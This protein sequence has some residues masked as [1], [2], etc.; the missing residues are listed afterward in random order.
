MHFNPRC[1]SWR[2]QSPDTFHKHV[3]SVSS[4]PETSYILPRSKKWQ[5]VEIHF[6]GGGVKRSGNPKYEASASSVSKIYLKDTLQSFSNQLKAWK[7]SY[8]WVLTR[9]QGNRAHRNLQY[10]SSRKRLMAKKER[11]KVY[12]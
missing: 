4:L 6:R 8:Y 7:W 2:T 5:S 10:L 1:F 11:P 3:K 9:F 12:Y